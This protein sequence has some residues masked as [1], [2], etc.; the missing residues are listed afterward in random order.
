THLAARCDLAEDTV[1]D[2][3][4]S[5]FAGLGELESITVAFKGLT[6][7]KMAADISVPMHPGARRWYDEH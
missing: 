2:V 1:Y 3:L 5:I 6:K 4:D 7:E